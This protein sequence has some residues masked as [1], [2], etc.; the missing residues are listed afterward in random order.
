MVHEGHMDKVIL[1]HCTS[2]ARKIM[3]CLMRCCIVE[4]FSSSIAVMGEYQC[5]MV[6]YGGIKWPRGKVP[7]AS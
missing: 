2:S 7:S 4:I 3:P 6:P 5:N 1:L